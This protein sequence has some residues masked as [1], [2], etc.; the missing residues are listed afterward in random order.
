M[1]HEKQPDNQANQ[2][3][4]MNPTEEQ[5][6]GDF[7]AAYMPAEESAPPSINQPSAP[8]QQS[9]NASAPPEPVQDSTLAPIQP[10][11]LI[12]PYPHSSTF[13]QLP[14]EPNV[15]YES[16][17]L[18]HQ[19]LAD[20]ERVVQHMANYLH[21]AGYTVE[22]SDLCTRYTHWVKTP[23]E[24]FEKLRHEVEPKRA[25]YTRQLE[26][27]E[28]DIAKA[29]TEFM[30]AMA[31]ARLPL[32]VH[33]GKARRHKATPQ[34]EPICPE[35]VERALQKDA[36][37]DDEVCGEQGVA[38]V[39]TKGSIWT[40]VGRWLF[41]FGAPLFAG[42]LLGV[43][44]GVITGLLSWET[45]QRAEALWLVALAA[46][47]GLFVEKLV[48]ETAYMLAASTA[49]ASEKRD[50]LPNIQPFPTMYSIVRVGLFIGAVVV[51]TVAV[52]LVDALGL[53]TL[54]KE[55]LQEAQLTG[56][57]AAEEFAFWVF[58][59]VGLIVS[60]PYIVNKAVKGWREPEMRQR[61]A[62]IAYLH[63]Q[64]LERRRQE[65]AVQQAFE[66]AQQVQDLYKERARLQQR[67][68][69][70]RARLDSARVNCIGNSRKFLTYWD[71]LIEWLRREQTPYAQHS[72]SPEGGFRSRSTQTD[73]LLR[74]LLRQFRR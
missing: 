49:A 4:R 50:A 37:S 67:I 66:K 65:P 39:S 58:L 72:I 24:E 41:E 8:P 64:Y 35:L 70:I 57:T 73:T 71:E 40:I 20:V 6:L 26:Q 5:P 23:A 45:L 28:R 11:P 18:V 2:Q 53:Y 69:E 16:P 25:E 62:R 15:F 46:I 22:A 21:H 1:E 74:R 31:R 44:L 61:E 13:W 55:R 33:D 60:A 34:P 59:L 47:I 12:E 30:Q 9:A 29:Q 14:L 63:R 17:L 51:L 7:A 10:S 68:E 36:P 54:Y 19:Q 52:A 27:V 3:S 48:G 42:L 43:N 32:P 56:A 38:P